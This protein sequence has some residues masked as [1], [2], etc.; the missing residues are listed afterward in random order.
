MSALHL[1]LAQ[2][3]IRTKSGA[4]RIAAAKRWLMRATARMVLFAY[5]M[6]LF[7]PVMP[8]LVDRLAHTFWSNVHIAVVHRVNGKEHVHYELM[9]AADDTGK[10]KAGGGKT[11]G[12]TEVA[13]HLAAGLQSIAPPFQPAAARPL[14]PRLLSPLPS[15][16]RTCGDP[17]PWS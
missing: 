11:K 8:I 13:P 16:L 1:I 9:K 15:G 4:G 6:F 17:P 2:P 3:K 10:E 5:A 12:E 7:K 14:Y